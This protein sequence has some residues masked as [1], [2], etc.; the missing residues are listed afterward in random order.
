MIKKI[1]DFFTSSIRREL[2]IGIAVVHAILMSIFSID[3]VEKEK[4]FLT[5]QN[6]KKIEGISKTLAINSTPWVLANDFAGLEEVIESIKHYPGIEK[7]L[8]LSPQGQVLAH[9]QKEYTGEY[10]SD[11]ISVGIL[12]GDIVTKI[13][14]ENSD[15]I[16]A[17]SP[18][19]R[20]RQHI[21]WARV[22]LNKS[23]I[24]QGLYNVKMKG[25]FYTL[26][27]IL[28]G[29]VFAY[30]IGTNLTKSIYKVI[31]TIKST[32][33]GNP[34][35]RTNLQRNDEIGV[36]ANEFDLM[37]QKLSDQ[38]TFLNIIID[39]IPDFIFFKDYQ[40][41]NGKYIG[42][43]N[44]FCNFVGKEKKDIVG[45]TDFDLFD[46][47][48]AEFFTQKDKQM[49]ENGKLQ[50]N[51]EWI[52]FPDGTKALMDT[53]KTP[54][55]DA[56]GNLVGVLGVSRDITE[57]DAIQKELDEKNKVIFEQAKLASMGEMIGNIAHQWR[58]PLSM[59][60]TIASSYKLKKEMNTLIDHEDLINEMSKIVSYAQYLSR[61]I[62]DF[63]NFIKGNSKIERFNLKNDTK[64]FLQLVDSTI[65]NNGIEVIVDLEETKELK[66]FPN[67]LI[68][69]FINI[70]NNAKDALNENR[71]SEKYI[72]ISEKVEDGNIVIKFLDN[73]GGIPDDIIGR[74]FEPYFTTKHQSQGTGIG[75]H[76]TYNLIT[77]GMKG[78]INVENKDFTFDEKEYRGAEFTITIPFLT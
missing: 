69:C 50:H 7:A 65:K 31:D 19:L 78:N 54:F 73:A 46:K 74:V 37:L 67:E 13:V 42:C 36:L 70:F 3:L 2:I 28:V 15:I 55:Y 21:G 62:D 18:I 51:E 10:I 57:R 17:V 20:D 58:Q 60:S 43:N 22:I 8:I 56:D 29:T 11:K 76:M 49:L 1:K 12:K 27:A 33:C 61:T 77:Q 30:I 35:I 4:S 40:N 71:D 53:L 6:Q 48:V 72:F 39:S 26:I 47:S 25:I 68:Q 16:D 59:I 5:L 44:G 24:N 9:S 32:K 63:R 64:I 34:K 45:K 14:F 41:Q 75:L 66:G 38:H 52:T 23:D